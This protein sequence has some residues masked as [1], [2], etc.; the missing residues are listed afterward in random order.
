MVGSIF[1]TENIHFAQLTEKEIGELDHIIIFGDPSKATGYDYFAL[2]LTGISKEGKMILIDSFSEN[3]L[4]KKLI[5]DQIKAWQK[6]YNIERTFIE[7]NG[8]IGKGFYN[9]C[10][11][12]EISV[13]GW[14]SRNNKFERI[15]ANYETITD[16]VLV[17]DNLNNR[18]FLSK[19]INLNKM[20]KKENIHD[21]NIDCLNNSI[22]AYKSLYRILGGN[23]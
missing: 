2:T 5:A 23:G 11:N 16:K 9:D 10:I 19:F 21:D 18:N 4:H 6:Q 20:L 14:Y 8:E 3:K 1:T 12:N 13:S 15:M 17:Q 7:T 22:I